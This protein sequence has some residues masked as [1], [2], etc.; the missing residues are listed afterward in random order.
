MP[1]VCSAQKNATDLKQISFQELSNEFFAEQHDLTDPNNDL[2]SGLVYLSYAL[3]LLRL[4]SY[5]VKS[6]VDMV[7]YVFERPKGDLSQEIGGTLITLS[8]L[9]SASHIDMFAR[10]LGQMDLN[11][12]NSHSFIE[13]KSSFQSRVYV[14]LKMAFGDGIANDTLERNHRFLE[15]SLELLQ[16]KGACK[17]GVSKMVRTIYNDR[18]DVFDGLFGLNKNDIA[19][20]ALISLANLCEASGVDMLANGEIELKSIEG[21]IGKIVSKHAMKPDDIAVKRLS[22]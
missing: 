18:Y 10:G 17:D 2:H 13:D 1:D 9:C 7:D 16:A 11:G 20:M 22:A 5:P 19:G 4:N 6:V 14:W 21:N 3:L 8:C 12:D 15:E